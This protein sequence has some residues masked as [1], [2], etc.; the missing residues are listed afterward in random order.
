MSK[1]SNSLNNFRQLKE[2][3]NTLD[4]KSIPEN[5]TQEFARNKEALI[6]IENYINL[7][8]ENLLPNKFL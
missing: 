3:V 7:L 1:I 8:D 4:I 6:Y 2:A 5:K